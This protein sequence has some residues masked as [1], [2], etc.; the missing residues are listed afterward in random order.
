MVEEKSRE[1]QRVKDENNNLKGTVHEADRGRELLIKELTFSKDNEIDRIK[2]LE[3]NKDAEIKV[4]VK[5]IENL[6][7]DKR[8]LEDRYDEA[9]TKNE[10]SSSKF[11]EEHHNTV[12]YFENLVVQHK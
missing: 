4:Y 9:I 12:K 3:K 6:K 10:I 2:E 11:A 8:D 1:M 5:I 7:K